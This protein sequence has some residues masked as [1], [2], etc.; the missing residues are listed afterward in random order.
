METFKHISSKNA[1][2]SDA[3]KYLLF[4]HDEFTMKPIL[5]DSGR[6][7]PRTNYRIATLNCDGQDFAV[8][9]MR[10]NLQYGKNLDRGD[11]KT[12]HYILGKDAMK[13]C[14][15]CVSPRF[16]PGE[17]LRRLQSHSPATA[18]GG[19]RQTPQGE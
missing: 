9:C 10:A 1:R 14:A 7:I 12:H 15:I 4:E 17:I 6:L 2:Y 18:K 16:Q 5:D 11:V 8:A 13:R 3:E 19:V